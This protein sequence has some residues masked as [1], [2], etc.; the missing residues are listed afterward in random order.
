M[1]EPTP[2]R[3]REPPRPRDVFH[4]LRALP[5]AAKPASLGNGKLNVSDPVFGL[6]FLFAGAAAS[7]CMDALDANDSQTTDISDPVFILNFLFSGGV[8]PPAPGPDT[9]GVDPT[10]DE[11]EVC[12]PAP[13]DS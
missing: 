3:L 11:L 13:C 12:V 4:L 1:S 7:T 10:P 9:P 8:A 5:P 2:P 6:N